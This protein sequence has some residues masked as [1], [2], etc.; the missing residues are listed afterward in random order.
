MVDELSR[1]TVALLDAY[2][3]GDWEPTP[4]EA[5]LAEELAR[6]HWTAA[7]FRSGLRQADRTV[8]QGRLVKLLDPAAA[9]LEEPNIAVSE[10]AEVALLQLRVLMDSIAPSP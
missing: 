2:R 1:E 10:E 6:G 7:W 9:V 5:C 3:A 4:E 8:V